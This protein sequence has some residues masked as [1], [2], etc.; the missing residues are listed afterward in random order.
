EIQNTLILPGSQ[1]FREQ[2]T[3]HLRLGTEEIKVYLLKAQ[4]I[5]QSFIQFQFELLNEQQQYLLD[6]FM[7]KKNNTVN[8]QDLWEAL[9]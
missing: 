4:L 6:Q 8:S 3:I 2:Q 9:K 7:L 1:I 5:T